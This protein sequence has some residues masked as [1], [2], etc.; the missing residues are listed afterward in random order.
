MLY[1]KKNSSAVEKHGTSFYHFFS[2]RQTWYIILSLIYIVSS[3]NRKKW[4]C[5]VEKAMGVF[6]TVIIR[7]LTRTIHVINWWTIQSCNQWSWSHRQWTCD[8]NHTHL[9]YIIK[10]KGRS[11]WSTGNSTNKKLIISIVIKARNSSNDVPTIRKLVILLSPFPPSTNAWVHTFRPIYQNF[12]VCPI[13][14]TH[15]YTRVGHH[16]DFT[17]VEFILWWRLICMPSVLRTYC[18]CQKIVVLQL[19]SENHFGSDFMHM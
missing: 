8:R 11:S 1:L 17:S 10:P 12:S 9:F 5:F 7:S 18:T 6:I 15:H 19:K 14:F 2:C 4:C 16:D 13:N 3:R